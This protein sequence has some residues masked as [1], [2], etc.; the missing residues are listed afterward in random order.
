[1][2]R[3]WHI[4][5]SILLRL[6]EDS[7]AN[8]VVNA[9][10][11]GPLHA[12][13]DVAYNMRLLKEMGLIAADIR[14]SRSGDGAIGIALARSMTHKGHDLLDSIRND[15]IW[16]R[17]QDTFKKKGVDMSVE[18]VIEVAKVTAKAILAG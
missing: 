7:R 6:E 4:I 1:M 10:S 17:V 8:A 14:E 11:F 2:K 9:N 13:Q 3:D 16:Q 15:T 12:E 18:L 5:R